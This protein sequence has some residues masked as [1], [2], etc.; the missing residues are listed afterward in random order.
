MFHDQNLIDMYGIEYLM[1][2][3]VTFTIE[4][5]VLYIYIYIY[6]KKMLTFRFHVNYNV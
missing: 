1:S 6:N 5:L 2:N 4:Y 3:I